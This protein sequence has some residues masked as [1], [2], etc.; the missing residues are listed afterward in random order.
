M[1]VYTTSDVYLTLR[2]KFEIYL[3]NIHESVTYQW[4]K[5]KM[6]LITNDNLLYC[7]I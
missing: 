4:P 3:S 2:F 1:F 7:L 6:L 5:R